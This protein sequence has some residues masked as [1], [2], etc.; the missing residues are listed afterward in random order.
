ML[1][2]R[3][4]AVA[5]TPLLV[6]DEKRCKC[7]EGAS[8]NGCASGS[9]G[10]DEA[11][12]HPRRDGCLFARASC[13]GRRPPLR[14]SHSSA[15][16]LLTPLP[17][18]PVRLCLVFQ[19]PW[20]A[21]CVA[22]YVEIAA[23]RVEETLF[24]RYTLLDL[25]SVIEAVSANG[26]RSC[27]CRGSDLDRRPRSAVLSRRQQARGSLPRRSCGASAIRALRPSCGGLAR[28]FASFSWA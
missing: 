15:L 3:W 5:C 23:A 10:N 20:T 24:L 19:H 13:R 25:T 26:Q 16:F 11:S 14:G 18:T 1:R 9:H 28:P 6:A 17:L 7:K 2:S 4:W 22:P 21:P 12:R 27:T 8:V